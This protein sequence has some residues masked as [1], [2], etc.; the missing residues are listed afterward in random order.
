MDKARACGGV[1]PLCFSNPLLASPVEYEVSKEPLRNARELIDIGESY[2][3]ELQAKH[4]REAGVLVVIPVVLPGRPGCAARPSPSIPPV[5]E[6]L[7]RSKKGTL[8]EA[9]WRGENSI[10]TRYERVWLYVFRVR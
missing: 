7:Y 10:I 5:D 9:W 4:E 8:T 1:C 3:V 2:E 6:S